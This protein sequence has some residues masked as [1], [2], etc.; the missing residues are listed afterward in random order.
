[1]LDTNN[2]EPTDSAQTHRN[3]VGTILWNLLW[4]SL[5]SPKKLLKVSLKLLR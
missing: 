2:L 5:P 1:M 3:N 4:N